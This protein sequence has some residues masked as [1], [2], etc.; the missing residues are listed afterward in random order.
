MMAKNGFKRKLIAI[1]S[2]DVKG[3]LDKT[4]HVRFARKEIL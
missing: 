2:A 3:W 4:N 1:L